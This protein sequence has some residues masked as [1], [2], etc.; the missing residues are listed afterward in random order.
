MSTFSLPSAGGVVSLLN[1]RG[2]RGSSPETKPHLTLTG[3]N[4]P[5]LSAFEDAPHNASSS[6]DSMTRSSGRRSSSSASSSPAT[7]VEPSLDSSARPTTWKVAADADKAAVRLPRIE[8]PIE[9]ERRTSAPVNRAVFAGDHLNASPGPMGT[10]PG[11]HLPPSVTGVF[12]SSQWDRPGTYFGPHPGAHEYTR[13]LG[14]CAGDLGSRA[15]SLSSS[16][17]TYDVTGQASG[18]SPSTRKGGKEGGSSAITVGGKKRYPCQHPGCDKT[19][20]TS[21]HAAR[22]NRIHTGRLC[23]RRRSRYTGRRTKTQQL[24]RPASTLTRVKRSFPILVGLFFFFWVYLTGQK[25]YR[26]TFPG[27]KAR[28]SR[29]DNSLQHYRTHILHPKGRSS[30]TAQAR[31]AAGQLDLDG[32]DIDG[33]DAEAEAK[34]ELGRR[35]LEDGTAIAVVHEVKDQHGRKKGETI[36]RMVGMPRGRRDSL[37]SSLLERER[38]TSPSSVGS[39]RIERQN[40]LPGLAHVE[41]GPYESPSDFWSSNVARHHRLSLPHPYSSVLRETP[42]HFNQRDAGL[43]PAWPGGADPRSEPQHPRS[44]VGG[45]R[46]E[47]MAPTSRLLPALPDGD[48]RLDPAKMRVGSSLSMPQSYARPVGGGRISPRFEQGDPNDLHRRSISMGTGYDR[49]GAAPAQFRHGAPQPT[50]APASHMASARSSQSPKSS[51]TSSSYSMPDSATSRSLS[52]LDK[53]GGGN[54]ASGSL[55]SSLSS[56]TARSRLMNGAAGSGGASYQHPYSSDRSTN[57]DSTNSRDA[58]PSSIPSGNLT[59]PLLNIGRNPL[60]S[61]NKADGSELATIDADRKMVQPMSSALRS[62]MSQDKITLPPLNLPNAAIRR[63]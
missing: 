17:P 12:P 6:T 45:P 18:A 2:R 41:P 7:S 33:L 8:V 36:E 56:L 51:P 47:S 1:D 19:F 60:T 43:A 26:C 11:E 5:L 3:K 37:H 16:G 39:G 53:L 24:P 59:L 58:S 30:Q 55:P 38:S 32:M 50:S 62:G 10:R 31:E 13:S 34:A 28:F 4:R 14:S 54:G 46:R 25:P 57:L 21:G 23:H 20:S 44:S 48:L 15:Y 40:S 29:Q 35:A 61:T 52:V 9:A 22:H 49:G 63:W 42:P 27:C